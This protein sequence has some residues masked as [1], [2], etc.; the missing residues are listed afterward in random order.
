MIDLHPSRK[1]NLPPCRLLGYAK[2]TQ[3]KASMKK[4]STCKSEEKRKHEP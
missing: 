2:T 4:R 3:L 1:E